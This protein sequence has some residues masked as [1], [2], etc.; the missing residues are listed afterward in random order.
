MIE[1]DV[2]VHGIRTACRFCSSNTC[3]ERKRPNMSEEKKVRKSNIPEVGE[4]AGVIQS[5]DEKTVH[6]FGFGK[7]LPD[8]VP[9]T[10]FLHDNGIKNP[11]ILLDSG[12]KVYG[13]ESWWS[14]EE[15]IN[16]VI[17]GKEII[18]VEIK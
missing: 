3:K 1:T 12:K 7:R 5:M 18:V 4:R 13:Y 2:C 14:S 11:C 6:F 8:E 15:K 16:E 17:K 10:G 9:P